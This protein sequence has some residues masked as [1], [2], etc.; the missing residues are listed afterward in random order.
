M[1]SHGLQPHTDARISFR[2]T[3]PLPLEAGL[4]NRH[5]VNYRLTTAKPPCH[6][7]DAYATFQISLC[8]CILRYYLFQFSSFLFFPPPP[9]ST[10]NFL[11]SRKNKTGVG[12]TAGDVQ[13]DL[14]RVISVLRVCLIRRS[15]TCGNIARVGNNWVWLRCLNE[16]FAINRFFL[17]FVFS[18]RL[19]LFFF[20]L[21]PV[22]TTIL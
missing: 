20:F 15:R 4:S 19:S 7:L 21:I 11:D 5:D 17:S 13:V 18:F 2:I 1:Q 9:P 12:I 14:Y 6:P 22:I 16:D 3:N 10:V 8:L